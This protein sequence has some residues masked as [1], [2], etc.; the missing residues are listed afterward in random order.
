MFSIA[1]ESQLSGSYSQF[2]V[3]LFE[4][5]KG[6]LRLQRLHGDVGGGS[7][8]KL[9]QKPRG[10]SSAETLQVRQDESHTVCKVT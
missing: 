1:R 4:K 8:E 3:F 6:W 5:H 9:D 2:H 7:A 10:R